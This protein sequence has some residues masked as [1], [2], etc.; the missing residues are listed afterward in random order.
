MS[1]AAKHAGAGAADFS[2]RAPALSPLAVYLLFLKFGLRA[3]GGPMVQIADQKEEL[4]TRGGW[5]SEAKFK[6]VYSLYAILPGPE[7]TELAC[8]F[9]RLAGGRVGGLMGGLGF[10]TPG[11]LLMLLFSWFYQR[12]GITNR[13]FL[14][15]F[16]G[17]QPA[18]CA[19]VFRACHKIGD[20]S[21]RDHTTSTWDWGLAG[22]GAAAAF[23]SV[24]NVNYFI[25]KAHLLLAYYCYVKWEEAVVA[26]GAAA[27]GEQR[28]LPHDAEAAAGGAALTQAPPPPQPPAARPPSP[29]FPPA[30]WGAA[31]AFWAVAPTL[32]YI[33]VIGAYGKLDELVPMGVGVAA[34]LGNTHGAQFIVG[35]LGGLVTFGGAYTAIP[36]VQYE[37]VTSGA[38]VLNAAFLDSIAVANLL[39]TPLVM[40]ITMIGY[41]SGTAMPGGSQLTGL[42]GALLMTLGMFLPAFAFPICFHDSLEAVMA[43]KGVFARVLDS[44]AATVVGQI[45]VTALILLRSAVVSPLQ[46]VIFVAALQTVYHLPHK[47]TPVLIVFTSAIA[48][49]VLFY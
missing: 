34:R 37:A 3:F 27:A 1:D 43:R 41:L 21:F 6:R 39:P 35:L 9:G 38:W 45:F 14:A 15:V 10:I 23:L 16:S 20:M 36:F 13:V 12:Y 44:V 30:L 33:G 29:C 40:F 31:C 46:A 48:G 7:A 5:I 26:A 11:L 4:V 28:P 22:V 42:W 17:L 19:M 32:V 47:Y 24:L 18:I 2:N 49:A 25:A 8:Y